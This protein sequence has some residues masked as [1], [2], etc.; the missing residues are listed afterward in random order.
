MEKNQD[1]EKKPRFKSLIIDGTKYKTNLSEAFENRKKW[2]PADP[3]KL[4]SYIPGTIYKLYIKEGQV[5]KQG[6]RIMI[7]EA[8]K[9]RNRIEAPMSGKIKKINVE[10]GQTIPKSFVM[11]EF[12]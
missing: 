5:V 6:T 11:I 10:E 4:M 7:L 2:E 3:K 9:M 8:M 1:K 12:E